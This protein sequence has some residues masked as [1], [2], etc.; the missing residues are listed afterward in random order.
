MTSLYSTNYHLRAHKRDAFIEFIKSLLLTPFVLHTRPKSSGSSLSSSFS[1]LTYGEQD[2]ADGL[3]SK[4]RND[5]GSGDKKKVFDKQLSEASIGW[6]DS[7]GEGKI[8]D[9]NV[10]RFCEILGCVEDLIRDHMLHDL[11]DLSEL[12]RLST[13]VPSIGRF[14]TPL[15]LRESFLRQNSKRS[16]AARRFVPPSFNDVRHILNE[17]QVAAIAPSLKLITFDGDCTLY[18]DGTDFAQDSQLVNLLIKLLECGLSVAIV[19]AAGYP[20]D[21]QKYESRLSGLLDGFRAS[22][23]PP[24]ALKRFFVL[25]GECNYLFRYDPLTQHLIYIPESEYPSFPSCMGFAD[26]DGGKE[27][28]QE[29]L[30]VAEETLRECAEVMGLSHTVGIL[31]KE[32]GI[33]VVVKEA[34]VRLSREQLDEFALSAQRRLNNHQRAKQIRRIKSHQSRSFGDLSSLS[35]ASQNQQQQYHPLP[36]CAFNGGQDVWVDIGNKLIGVSILQRWL[37]CEGGETLHVGDQFLSTGND[38]STRSACCTVWITNPEETAEV[39]VELGERLGK[40]T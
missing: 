36:F 16:I 28:V 26:E 2:N 9:R 31:R 13:L 12:S 8:R 15:P 30:D 23:L 7:D 22:S 27:R 5:D 29:L 34:G 33:G 37:G 25:G 4:R 38:I 17:A 24:E 1:N 14:F 39:L 20:G 18:A 11:N 3:A 21:V 32:R 19:T 6:F 40:R 10:E 35:P